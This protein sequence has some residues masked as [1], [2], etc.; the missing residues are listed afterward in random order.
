MIIPKLVPARAALKSMTN[1]EACLWKYGLRAGQMKMHVFKRQAPVML[2]V[3]DFM[4][5]ALKLI[6]EVDGSGNADP[7][8]KKHAASSQR[9]LETSGFIVLRF[10]DEDVLEDMN[11]VR[12]KISSAIVSLEKKEHAGDGQPPG[13]HSL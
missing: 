2:Y 4:C 7:E 1:A 3:A 11:D 12:S 6:I 5:K 13:R 8:A 10:K 9:E